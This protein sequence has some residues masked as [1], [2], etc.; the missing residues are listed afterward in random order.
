MKQLVTA[1]LLVLLSRLNG[2]SQT[3]AVP[4]YV[5]ISPRNSAYFE[6]TN[7]QTYIPIGLNLCW[8]RFI[9]NETEGLAKMEFYFQELKKNG[10][11][12]ARI[13]LS[14]PF[15]EIETDRVG[16]YNPQRLARLDNLMALA[17]R[18]GIRLKFCLEN[19]RTL[20]NNP[21]RFPGSVPFDR[22]IYAASNGGPL[23]DMDQY[24]SSDTGK[25]L[26]L[27]R[28][29]Q[30]ANRY[31]TNPNVFGWELWNEMDAVR[32]KN[33]E[34]WTKFM[35]GQCQRLFPNHL[36]MQSLGSY[37]KETKRG[38]YQEVARF[39]DNDVAQVHRY[40][41]AGAEWAVCHA[42]M[43]LVARQATTDLL[44][45]APH[46]PVLLA[47]TGAVEA[48][49]AGP[50]NLYPADT[51]GVLLHDI[52]FAPFFAGAA[53]P[54][55]GWHWDSYVEKNNLWWQIGRFSEAI[56]G[57]DPIREQAVPFITSLPNGLKVY[58]LRGKYQLLLWIRDEQ[59]TWQTELAQGMP[60]RTVRN[61]TIPLYQF[62]A[63]HI[64]IYNPWKNQHVA[65][66]VSDET[67]TL[68][69]FSRSIIV[70]LN[71]N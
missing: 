4:D 26:Y 17:E 31:A 40:L 35:L 69:S 44:S 18:Y 60:T 58:G 54:G 10:G 43:E 64:D 67:I 24:L 47:E 68:P 62:P 19:F 53:G 33:W 50:W 30:F 41:D 59:S 70:K 42:P 3:V 46:K 45:F 52:L 1:T 61:V 56:R 22:P 71:I 12:Y 16:Q 11:N 2:Y 25:Q 6:T 32:S 39:T 23:T 8:P 29:K 27:D 37:D 5:R 7:G 51:A 28:A 20:T 38:I 9:D 63:K 34:P 48:N 66:V 65:G 21:V 14:A 36:V 55:H 57:F 15:W 49:H 13:W